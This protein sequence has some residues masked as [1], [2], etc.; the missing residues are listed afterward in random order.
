MQNALKLLGFYT[1][2]VDGKFG[3][4][5]KG[6]RHSVSAGQRPDRRRPCGHQDPAAALFSGE[7][8]HFRRQFLLVQFFLLRLLPASGFTRTLRKGYT[9]TDV[10]S[11]QQ[12]LKDL[13]FYTGSVDGVYGTGSMAAVKTF[14]RQNGLTADGLVGSRTY[15][16]L[17]SATSGSTSNSGSDNS[18]SV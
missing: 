3:S 2:G 12:K 10:I 5:T 16:V 15:A 11:V 17:M 13:G 8:W 18:L 14:Q 1:G 9:G 7:Q 6:G 4:G